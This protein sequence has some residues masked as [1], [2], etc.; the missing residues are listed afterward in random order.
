MHWVFA[1]SERVQMPTW[2]GSVAVDVALCT[3]AGRCVFLQ[4]LDG[5]DGFDIQ[6]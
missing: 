2:L 3:A 5:M 1:P 4:E 6:G